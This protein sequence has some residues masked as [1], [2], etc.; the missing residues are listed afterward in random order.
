VTR[1]PL[2][3]IVALLTLAILLSALALTFGHG[4]VAHGGAFCS[5][6][7]ASQAASGALVL[8][9]SIS[10]LTWLS[11]VQARQLERDRELER[12]AAHNDRL[13]LVG[14]LT[15]GVAHDLRGP[16]TVLAMGIEEL[17]CCEGLEPELV[18]DLSESYLRLRQLSSDLTGFCRS[19]GA[20]DRAEASAV[21][22]SAL[23]M[24]GP[25]LRGAHTVAFSS[26]DRLPPVGIGPQRL[27]QVLLNLVVNAVDA[28]P[29]GGHIELS[30]RVEGDRALISVQDDGPGIEPRLE[31][32]LFSPFATT[33]PAGEGTGL[34]LFI[35]R[36][37]IE[38]V[39]GELR[40]ATSEFG[41][42]F[43]VLLP[44]APSAPEP[45]L[46]AR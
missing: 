1:S 42:R 29:G 5:V 14:T 4:A 34:G 19:E 11:R 9:A 20:E 15:A 27:E 18:E 22:A 12:R 2:P 10:A 26:L 17:R 46:R 13:A 8:G 24:A 32:K 41:A 33:K 23:R 35:S 28:T 36:R 25:R 6:C 37:L 31:A 45:G 43:E 16:L 7:L 21:L 3:L 40:L 44:L 38:E 30:A 39:G